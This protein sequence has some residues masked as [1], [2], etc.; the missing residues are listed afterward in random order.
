MANHK[1]IASLLFK[2]NN[3]IFLL[4]SLLCST[5]ISYSAIAQ[6]DLFYNN[7]E[8]NST[9]I[10]S[11]MSATTDGDFEGVKFFVKS[12]SSTINQKNIGGATALHLA[13]R[14]KNF[15]IAKILVENG[16]DV[17]AFDEEGWTPLMR[18][19]LA[20]EANIVNLLL[21]NGANVGA[22][23]SFKDSAIIHAAVSNCN[24]CLST[25]FEKSAIVKATDLE[26][27]K[28]QIHDAFVIARNHDNRDA[29]TLL[30]NALDDIIRFSS[31][32]RQEKVVVDEVQPGAES[33]DLKAASLVPITLIDKEQVIDVIL[34]DENIS[35]VNDKNVPLEQKSDDEIFKENKVI[36]IDESKDADVPNLEEKKVIVNDSNKEDSVIEKK[37]EIS[38]AETKVI[39]VDEKKD[40]SVKKDKAIGKNK[41]QKSVKN[42][43]K[44]ALKANLIADSKQES[45]KKESQLQ[46]VLDKKPE[47]EE[48]KVL[49]VPAKEVTAKKVKFK[50]SQGPIVVKT[51]ELNIP[52]PQ[53]LTK[54]V[55]AASDEVVKNQVDKDQEN[56]SFFSSIFGF[57]SKENNKTAKEVNILENKEVEEVSLPKNDEQNI[58]QEEEKPGFFAKLFGKK[59]SFEDD[60]EDDD[61]KN[62][63]EEEVKANSVKEQTSI[64]KDLE[65]NFVKEQTSIEDKKPGFF[66]RLFNSLFSS[67][68]EKI[69][70]SE[71]NIKPV[72][73]PKKFKLSVGESA[74]DK[75]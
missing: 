19:S 15:E 28:Q 8:L 7:K 2:K 4:A 21:D 49:E 42:N 75:N 14:S 70:K 33:G 74:K 37:P 16:A 25:I 26:A 1:K 48:S 18:A 35:S 55:E 12:E 66:S 40:L 24:D 31:P 60:E 13:C 38:N 43:K 6:A 71:E 54:D 5:S 52:E 29:Q 61:K 68:S 65:Q 72:E 62:N 58:A 50:F 34:N 46:L 9:A 27:L 17:N 32:V 63:E 56:K 36:I 22:I 20:G 64:S 45:I 69:D 41:R 59:S 3:S 44:E 39:V 23:N 73:K 30:S 10:T 53:N 47:V 67:K 51:Q 57:F 11:L